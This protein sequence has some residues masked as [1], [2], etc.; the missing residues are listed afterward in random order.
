M[1][2]QTESTEDLRGEEATFGVHGEGVDAGE[3]GGEFFDGAV[4]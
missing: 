1:F 4:R 2:I 3:A